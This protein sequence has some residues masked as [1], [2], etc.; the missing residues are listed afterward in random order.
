M[1]AVYQYLWRHRM[2]G[3]RLKL[4]DGRAVEVIDPGRLNTDAGPDF[5]NAKVRIGTTVMAG[6]IEIHVKASDWHRHGHHTDRT[7]DSVMLHVVGL[8]DATVTR[9]DGSEIDQTEVTVPQEFYI[10]FAA[11]IRDTRTPRCMPALAGVPRL[12]LTDWKE[13]LTIERLQTKATRIIDTWH[14]TGGDWHQTMFI[15]LARA[16]GFSLNAEPF[17]MLARATPLHFMRRHADNPIQL[18]AILF[19]QASM[20]DSAAMPYD[21]YYQT[22]CREYSFLSRKYSLRPILPGV[23]RYARTRPQNMPHRRIALLAST[24][25]HPAQG[26]APA[27]LE[28]RG[29]LDRLR[30]V[31]D[32][33]I[34]GYWTRHYSFGTPETSAPATLGRQSVNILLINVAAPYYLA[35]AALR[36][37]PEVAESAMR[38]L[39]SLPP[40]NNSIV[41]GWRDAGLKI[42]DA[43]ESQAVIQ[44]T[45]RYCEERRCLDCRIG[46]QLLRRGL[47]PGIV[48]GPL[49]PHSVPAE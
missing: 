44:L 9:T 21:G 24:L 45:R 8:D 5:F 7:Y 23:W 48:H 40:E 1:E 10:T 3:L 4:R 15:T 46:H 41:N 20:L 42:R 43:A 22:L 25:G 37:E 33:R 19:G 16:L 38:L 26:L 14:A 47:S 13:S 34:E 49:S 18:Q 35:Y 29:D 17:E 39:E 2:F 28:A 27:I 31:F 12:L 11:L 36:Q 6:N 32:W 30:A